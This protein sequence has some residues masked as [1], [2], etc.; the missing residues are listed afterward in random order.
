MT[1]LKTK[2][3][4]RFRLFAKYSFAFLLIFCI[5]QCTPSKDIS[6]DSRSVIGQSNFI[7]SGTII[8]MN[9]SNIDVTTNDPTAIVLV[10]E[11][12]DAIPPYDQMK[13]KEITVLLASD[14]DRKP[15]E[16][17]VFYTMGWYYGKTLGV[18]EI[19][20]NLKEVIVS[21]HKNRIVEERFNIENDSLSAELKRASIVVWGTIVE[22]DI[23]DENVPPFGSEHD[24][25]FRK[26]SIEIK[27]ILKGDISENLIDVYYASSVDV[28]WSESPKPMKDQEG[29]FLLH[30]DQAPPI[31][32]MQGYT[33][34][35]IRDIQ[36]TENLANIQSLLNK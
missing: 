4:K 26:A 10:D 5:T 36:P 17:E 11:V 28:M 9:A 16:K 6:E 1:T 27:E 33:M 7:F 2:L 20:N 24:P 31:F 22:T 8:K 25:E 30:L 21:D 29:I 34:L 15:G 23:K 32:K 19:P 18:K 13:G 14:R 12:I 3:K 35:D